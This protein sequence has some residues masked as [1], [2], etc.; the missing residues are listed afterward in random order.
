[1]VPV[2]GRGAWGVGYSAL[3]AV[4]TLCTSPALFGAGTV[5]EECVLR[6]YDVRELLSAGRR[7]AATRL[8][9]ADRADSTVARGFEVRSASG[10]PAS[11][12]ATR[13]AAPDESAAMAAELL[14]LVR[15][16][17]GEAAWAPA[18]DGALAIREG[19]LCVWQRP[20]GQAR[21]EALLNR[22]RARAGTQVVVRVG[23][24]LCPAEAAEGLRERLKISQLKRAQPLVDEGAP[25]LTG[26]F[27]TADQV[28]AAAR[29]LHGL[30]GART[31]YSGTVPCLPV[32]EA[33]VED[34]RQV[35][36]VSQLSGGLAARGGGAPFTPECGVAGV[37]SVVRLQPVPSAD[38]AW[39]QLTV[40]AR[41]AYLASFET[42]PQDL[43]GGLV[44]PVHQPVVR[45]TN[46]DMA[47]PVPAGQGVLVSGTP[48]TV[49][50]E[51]GRPVS[52]QLVCLF[53]PTVTQGEAEAQAAQDQAAALKA[54][55]ERPFGL[56][57][58]DQ[59]LRAALDA[60][61]QTGVRIAV[62]PPPDEPRQGGVLD[63]R[64]T[65]IRRET[66]LIEALGALLG[67]RLERVELQPPNGM[68]L[69]LGPAGRPPS[70][71][72]AGADDSVGT[73]TVRSA[74][75]RTVATLGVRRRDLTPEIR[76]YL[77]EMLSEVLKRQGADTRRQ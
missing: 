36:F 27:L 62:E 6:T 4:L 12:P 8:G 51:W 64:V 67:D 43:G 55:L 71:R 47:L 23:L 34:V 50:D 1:M 60:L 61:Q 3:A 42:R 13:P 26:A 5:T 21:V 66:T 32:R 77:E 39:V 74:D 16:A 63:Q 2:F 22:L 14:R 10:A 35:V 46:L 9:V 52:G 40:S 75:G 69:V 73:L 19:L 58:S 45:T 7:T 24:Y 72:P 65:L 53:W 31:L 49:S 38:F 56:A 20:S 28:A 17:A 44:G 30:S 11:A 33:V 57:L 54:A 48:T 41:I 25:A 59:P 70:A 68:R 15:E 76:A 18:G 29:L 37:G